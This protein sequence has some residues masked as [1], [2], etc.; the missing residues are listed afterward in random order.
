MMQYNT[1]QWTTV[2]EFKM[3]PNTPTVSISDIIIRENDEISS[4]TN[5]N[6]S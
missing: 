2:L 1:I 3:I 5:H 4:L 6:R